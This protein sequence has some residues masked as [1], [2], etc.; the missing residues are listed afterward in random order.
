MK[1]KPADVLWSN[2]VRERDQFL[3]QFDAGNP[4]FAE[5]QGLH[6]HHLFGRT[7]P[8]RH[9]LANGISLCMGHHRYAHAHPLDF[10]DMIRDRMGHD[11]YDELRRECKRL[12]KREP[13]Q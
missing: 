9:M 2:L 11:E 7:G 3:C 13:I 8:G 5:R 6:A 1:L 12:T 10:H 4:H